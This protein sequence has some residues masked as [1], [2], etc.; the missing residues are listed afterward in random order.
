MNV[1]Q[2]FLHKYCIYWIGNVLSIVE[3]FDGHNIAISNTEVIQYQ[4]HHYWI[5]DVKLSLCHNYVFNS[6]MQVWFLCPSKFSKQLMCKCNM[7]V[8]YFHPLSVISRDDW[9]KF[10]LYVCVS[11]VTKINGHIQ[12]TYFQIHYI[13]NL[14]AFQTKSFIFSFLNQFGDF[15]QSHWSLLPCTEHK[16]FPL[17]HLWTGAVY[18]SRTSKT[19]IP[20]PADRGVTSLCTMYMWREV[21]HGCLTM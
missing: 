13:C 3:H 21:I 4:T 15:S 8:I 12:I 17:I 16:R 1:K 14:W 7:A 5:I 18:S 6:L 2:V 19:E 9:L 10:L 11:F 20:I